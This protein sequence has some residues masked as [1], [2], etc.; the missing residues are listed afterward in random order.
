MVEKVEGEGWLTPLSKMKTLSKRDISILEQSGIG[1]VEALI[2]RGDELEEIFE[3]YEETLRV[4]KVKNIRM[5]ALTL[6]K[7]WMVPASEWA[8]VEAQQ[9]VFKTGSN[10]LDRILG[11]GV[12]SM[13]VA[14]FFGEFGTGKSQIL[15]TIMVL[16]L[17]ELA[18]RTA[19]YI[20]CEGTYRD[21][22][23]KQIAK[24]RGFDPENITKRIVLLKPETSEDLLEIVR[25]LYLTIEA[26]KSALIVCDSL[27]SHLRAEY[28]GREMLQ[29]RQQMLLR[30]LDRLKRLASLYNIGVAVSNQVV[31]VPTQTFSPFGD[32]RATGGHII[33]HNTEPRVFV[34]KAGASPTVRIAKIEDSCWLPPAEA[35][36]RIT[37]KGVED[38]AEEGE[39]HGETEH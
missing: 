28:Y 5:E 25:R 34:R 19:I 6:K 39:E 14:E 37:L 15:D 12:H 31:A 4:K 23:V 13:Y 16:A 32:L 18:E 33:A 7:R 38:L 2:Y 20:D 24:L 26:R 29:P 3:A 30:I 22:R 11:G 21:N 10:E 35:R 36:F 17:N 1:T 9:I 27:I 8:E